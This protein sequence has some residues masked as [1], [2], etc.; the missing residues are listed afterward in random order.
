MWKGEMKSGEEKSGEEGAVAEG[1]L[2]GRSWTL[3]HG[4]TEG[5]RGETGYDVHECTLTSMREYC[6]MSDQKRL[7][8]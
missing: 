1:N 7:Q 4:P 3:S 6:Q 5:L 8:D 2:P